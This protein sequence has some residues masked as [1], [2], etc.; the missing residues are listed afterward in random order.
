VTASPST[1]ISGSNV[2]LATEV[3][4]ID[5]SGTPAGSIS[6]NI[7]GYVIATEN[8]N[9]EGD[10]AFQFSTK[11]LPAGNYTIGATYS[12]DSK[13]TASTSQPVMITVQ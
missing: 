4:R 10:A 3:R 2:L 5:T 13:D 9:S 11:G 7:N 12:G 1:V 8:L 6:V